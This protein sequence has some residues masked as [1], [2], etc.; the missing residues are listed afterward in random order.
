MALGA[1]GNLSVQS[2]AVLREQY[3][4][5]ARQ[6]PL[7]YALMFLNVLFLAIV[8][9]DGGSWA[10]SFVAPLVLTVIIAVR[11][12]AWYA[13]RGAVATDDHIRRYLRFT[14]FRAGAFSL[15]FG[16]WGLYLFL[17]ADPFHTTAIALFIFVGSISCCYCLQALPSAARLVLLFG[18]MPVT[19]GL[20][21]S[22]DW[23]FTGMGLTFLLGAGVILRT[24]ATTRSAVFESL[25]SRSEMAT[26]IEAL[27]RSEEHYRYSVEL[28][29]QIPWISDPEGQIVEV[30]PRWAE[31]TGVPAEDALG[32]GWTDF[33]HPDDLPEVLA[34]WNEALTS[35]DN[36]V[37]D[38]RYRVRNTDG[39]YRWCRARANPRHDSDGRIVSW[40]GT[41]EDIHDQVTAELALRESEERYRLASHA[42]NDV[43]WD[44]SHRT[45]RIEW[46]NG[47]VEV[48]GYPEASNGTAVSW[49]KERV[50]PEDLPGVEATYDR[51]L[52]N[53][54]D[55]W[56]HEYRF[57]AAQGNFINLFSRGYVVRDEEGHAVRSIGALLDVTAARRAEEELRWAANHDPL[58]GLPNRKLFAE[59]LEQA[60]ATAAADASYVCVIVIDVDGFKLLNDSMGHA[61]GDELLRTIARRLQGNLPAEA[62]VA[63]LGG[64]EFAVIVPGLAPGSA[65]AAV[66]AA[67]K[68]VA[69]TLT[70]DESVLPV[71]ISAGAAVWPADGDDAEEI[72]K[73]ADLA[74][75]AA[76]AEGAGVVREFRPEM[77]ESAESRK[78]MLR[79]ARE[80]LRDDR[81]IPFYQAKVDLR[82]G[83]VIGFEALLRWHHHR[84]GLQPPDSIQAAFD[85]SLLASELT[86]RM[87]DRVL[88]DVVAFSEK[89]VAFGRIAINGSLSDFRR[90]DFADR[91]L[92]KFQRAG[93]SPT[94][95]ELE[96]TESV[97]V[98]HLALN[99]ERALRTLVAEGVSIALD[100][101]GT[102]YASLTHL[103]QFPVHVLKIDRSFISRLDSA[104]SADFAIVHGVIDIAHRMD[105]VTVAE[106]VEND[107]QLAQLRNLGCDIAQGYLFSR[108]IS[109]E[110]VPAWL[111][112][113]TQNLP[114]WSDAADNRTTADPPT[115]S[116]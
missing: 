86:D 111:R 73:S 25:R 21:V 76:K 48:F 113:W 61:A 30:G 4:S 112:K 115:R 56:S 102:G 41:L 54:Q 42:T 33:L 57:R 14:I 94:L 81:I 78:S 84:R 34:H 45:D 16:G 71:S 24:I 43:I 82:S 35:V 104:D 65:R 66:D 100:D 83:D 93:L 98:D 70:I 32:R 50:H 106:G 52:S 91:I 23:Y 11:A 77:R 99:V 85:D 92:G 79:E 109:A 60:L 5:L 74:L 10:V 46:G 90:D 26:L 22:R 39:S 37:A 103:Q 110:R 20:L 51:V 67:L 2:E 53:L 3:A 62:T 68:G 107:N 88:A 63:R 17:A 7:M 59:V 15:L 96:V 105:I 58:T 13:R 97:F 19:I 9:A 29:P 101:F 38:V 28:N 75:Y 95:L 89:G 8:T 49:W 12:A 47:A 108:A 87:I 69:D 114:V 55:S 72:L 40:Y 1:G 116:A 27:R 31:L 6:V 64:D 18:A 36:A 44:W 80:A